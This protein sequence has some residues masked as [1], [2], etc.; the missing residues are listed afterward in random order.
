MQNEDLRRYLDRV[1]GNLRGPG[2]ADIL[3]EIESHIWDRA[4][5]LA[6]RHEEVVDVK[7]VTMHMFEIKQTEKGWRAQVILD[8]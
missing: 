4:E 7:A 5:A 1:E 6:R 3:R 8:I 2:K